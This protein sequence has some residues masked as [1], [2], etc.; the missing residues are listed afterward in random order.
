MRGISAR[1]RLV[2]RSNNYL[3]GGHVP[4][5]LRMH[6]DEYGKKDTNFEFTS[7]YQPASTPNRCE[8]S[9]QG[10]RGIKHAWIS[11]GKQA[12]KQATTQA[13]KHARKQARKHARKQARNQTSKQASRQARKLESTQARKL[14]STQ[15]SPIYH[16]KMFLRFLSELSMRRQSAR[17]SWPRTLRS[18]RLE[19]FAHKA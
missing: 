9:N 10:I 6:T 17:P 8:H 2:N 12:S 14:E 15:A 16:S 4:K 11:S 19:H 18:A 13:S 1:P 7:S 3:I 5:W